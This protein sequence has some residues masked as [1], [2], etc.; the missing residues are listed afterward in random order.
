MSS[1]KSGTP[2]SAAALLAASVLAATVLAA[3]ARAANVEPELASRIT[4][5]A[6]DAWISVILAPRAESSLARLRAAH[7]AR[8]V[9]RAERH[10]AVL[11]LLQQEA[12]ASQRAILARVGE[13]EQ[14]GEVRGH[15]AYWLANL[16]V[17]D[18]H[19][20]AL[21]ELAARGDV[22]SIESNFR[23]TLIAPIEPSEAERAKAD[24]AHAARR[25]QGVGVEPGLRAI[26]ADRVWHEL[27]VTGQGTLVAN[28]D[29]GVDASHP[30]LHD[31]WRGL[32]VDADAAWRNYIT[33]GSI[34]TD[35]D[36]HGTHVMGTMC[37][38]SAATNDT[39]GVAWEA[40]WIATN[41]LL[42]RP[43]PPVDNAILD[44]F[45][46]MADPD[47]DLGTVD[48]VPDVVQNSW[49][50]EPSEGHGYSWCDARWWEV[51]D[52]C[53]ASGVVV[54]FSAGNS[55]PAPGTIVSPA[56]RVASE[57]NC[58]S[59]GAINA[60]EAE[61][62]YDI[63]NF[64][65]RG[66]SAC[67]QLSIKPEVVAPGVAV[68]SSI[69]GPGGSYDLLS[70]TSMA[71]PHVAGTVALIRQVNPDISP[72]AVKLLLM[73]TAR[74]LSGD[75]EDNTY[76]H[77]IID[78]YAAV[79]AAGA[80]FGRLDG[81]VR[82]V[83][84]GA[85]AGATVNVA[86][87]SWR[88]GANGRFSGFVRAGSYPIEV[89]HA[90]L[91]QRST[92]PVEITLG[93]RTEAEVLLE[94][95]ARPVITDFEVESAVRSDGDSLAVRAAVHD[96]SPVTQVAVRYR[97]PGAAWSERALEMD[98]LGVHRGWI[99]EQSTGL[100]LEAELTAGDLWG[101]EA[102]APG[103]AGPLRLTIQH[104]IFADDGRSDQGWSYGI[105]GDAKAGKWI[106][107]VP[108][109]S[110]FQGRELEP[111]HD[112]GGDGYCFVTGKGKPNVEPE[113]ADV[114]GGCVTLESPRLDLSRA[115]SAVLSYWRWLALAQFPFD[116]HLSVDA[117]SDDGQT[118]QNLESL[119]ID[120]ARWE[121]HALALE[122]F[123]SLTDAVRVR[124]VACDD[125]EDTIVE[126]AIDDVLIESLPR[127][128]EEVVT[129]DRFSIFP[130]PFRGRTLFRVSLPAPAEASLSI[131]DAAGRRVRTLLDR[132]LPAGESIERWDGTNDAGARVPSG[133][134]FARL[135][136]D[137]REVTARAVRVD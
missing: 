135:R 96:Y 51:I 29:T 6:N 75:L 31:R 61:F 86:D 37:G 85:V 88:T 133:L 1:R 2:A 76:G 39:I 41:P 123:L 62:P 69:P 66:P 16:I 129:V 101:N 45:Q 130:N 26:G 81:V 14:A 108:F 82:F 23:A 137:G 60:Q 128:I 91:E 73:Q 65:S 79:V 28:I 132:S 118:W 50:V 17:I 21:L 49:G 20:A 4:A 24:V 18:A 35:D 19:P 30:A 33:A 98:S 22:A 99:P 127:S 126:A 9:S 104:E 55:G 84:G 125:G 95:H 113:L 52:H 120:A 53:E 124:F 122:S 5:A 110:L 94:D 15:T 114:D 7:A 109:G 106:R 83:G 40:E 3:G 72:E 70:G 63:A 77:G 131:Y 64:S 8:S 97:R 117:S 57:T 56:S 11:D 12:D 121:H 10:R 13:L 54:T 27:G 100:P 43:G 92:E 134:Y 107:M 44:A 93:H 90:E 32:H 38:L 115:S 136:L 68:R 48:D 46:W 105:D 67:D 112:R 36:R 87:Q 102:I 119:S 42:R 103:D 116:G 78:A 111:S 25:A 80:N 74:D 58:F 47:G 59:V 34:P 89:F 71:G